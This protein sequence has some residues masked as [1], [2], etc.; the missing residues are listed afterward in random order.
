[1]VIRL[2]RPKADVSDWLLRVGSA[3]SFPRAAD[4]RQAFAAGGHDKSLCDRT[5][6]RHAKLIPRQF[7]M[8]LDTALEISSLHTDDDLRLQDPETC[9]W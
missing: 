9:R 3:G 4:I 8:S 2:G 7:R 1:V 5:V 6:G